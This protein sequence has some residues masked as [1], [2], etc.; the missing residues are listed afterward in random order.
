MENVMRLICYG[1]YSEHCG[2]LSDVVHLEIMNDKRRW[3]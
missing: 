1:S 2:E 3:W